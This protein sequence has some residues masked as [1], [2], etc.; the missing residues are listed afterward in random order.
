MSYPNFQNYPNYNNQNFNNS[1]YQQYSGQYPMAVPYSNVV[2]TPPQ[3]TPQATMQNQLQQQNQPTMTIQNGGFI[4]VRSIEEAKNYPIAPG[5]SITFKDETVPY[6]YT[7]TMG[8]S[9]LDRPVFE[10]FKLVKEDTPEPIQNGQETIQNQQANN[11]QVY[12]SKEQIEALQQE[13]VVL[14]QEIEILKQQMNET[15]KKSAP[16][17]K[18]EERED[19][20]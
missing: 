8:F 18:K 7:K 5:N 16:R 3:I 11:S 4:S 10:V 9:Q 6:V 13:I 12:I 17:P 1:L 14:K 2:S 19:N 20:E 15:G